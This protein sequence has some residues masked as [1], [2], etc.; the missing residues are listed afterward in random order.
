MKLVKYIFALAAAAAVQGA[1][2]QYYS[3]G[4]DPSSLRWRTIRTPEVRVVYPDTV[5]NIARRTL[6]Y[7]ERLQPFES[8]GF[9]RPPLRLS[10]VMHPENMLSNG[11]T[12]W[13]PKRID[14][15]TSPAVAGYSMPWLKQLAAHEYRHAV[16]YNNLNRGVIRVL[17]W[18]LGQQGSV[19]GLLFMPLWAIEGDAVTFETQVSTFGRGLQPSFSIHYRAA[20]RELLERRNPDKWFCG[21]YRDYIPDHYHIG[22]QLVSYSYDRYGERLWNDVTRFGVRNPYCFFTVRTGLKKYASTTV[23]QLFR[24][25]FTRLNDFWEAHPAPDD[26]SCALS[27][28]QGIYTVY[29][30]PQYAGGGILSLKSDL[31]HA[32]RFVTT[33]S[34]GT[35]RPLA[36]TGLLSSRPATDGQRVWWTEYRNSTLFA[37]R[38][39]SRLCFMDLGDGRTHTVRGIRDALYPTPARDRLARIAYRPDGRYSLVISPADAPQK[40]SSTLLLPEGIEIHGLAWD[41]L[42]DTFSVIVTDDQG[43]H[44]A[45][46][47]TAAGRLVPL[48]RSAYITLSDLRAAGGRLYFGSTASGRDEAHMIDLADTLQRRITD[49]RYGAF[50]PSPSPDGRHAAVTQFGRNGY[51]LAVQSLDTAPMHPVPWTETP[52]E[53]LNPPHR[54]IAHI[55]LD[56][57]RYTPAD[58]EES[59]RQHPS[60]RR[61][62]VGG[63][64]NI[65]SWM[66]LSLDIFSAVDEHKADMAFGATILSQNLQSS[67][68][69]YASYGWSRDEGSR[70]MGAIR[71]SGF[72]PQLSFEGRYGGNQIIYSM[73]VRDNEGQTQEQPV[74]QPERY[75]SL[76]AGISL[77]L[78][79]DAGYRS[80][81]LSLS[82][83]WNYSNGL[84][85]RI[86]RL[87]RDPETGGA[88]NLDRIGY[89]RGLHKLS[90]GLSFSE[91]VRTAYRDFLP[92]FGYVA[93]VNYSADPSNRLFSDMVSLYG[94]L[95]LPGV[96]AHHSLSL[97]AEYRTSVGGWRDASGRPALTFRSSRLLPT[98]FRSA[99]VQSDNCISASAAYRL[100]LCYP[101]GGIPGVLYFRRIRLGAEFDFARFGSAAGRRSIYSYG[102]E[103]VFDINLLR[104]PAAGG[105]AFTVRVFRT[106]DGRTVAESGIGLPF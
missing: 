72:G 31:A 2:A 40:P 95:Y 33:G 17:S 15:L 35:E 88:A 83:D 9:D 71:Y 82:A 65:H 24:D 52:R 53:I 100:P 51:R 66:P 56:T 19:I 67:A 99:D 92:R 91:Q 62:R 90:F 75:Y 12:M 30:W 103:A 26:S 3:W 8:E 73:T 79:L 44:I 18:P 96:A 106:S 78:R 86:D 38:V 34:D 37:E 5:E 22:Y 42:T 32:A 45:A 10:F 85:A 74:P 1:A 11:L 102:L 81:L 89:K 47:D 59:Q 16:Q 60:R 93:A 28:Q 94:R 97:A 57:V 39:N 25:T 98:G 43:M 6:Y 48:T 69:A 21:S 76:D 87:E 101:D 4:S 77:P 46:V 7:I 80:R 55:N 64:F 105:M 23:P 50:A 20:G 68:T 58:R 41:D 63:L 70:V 84:V 49:S 104:L 27:P 61:T 36:H 54:R 29:E 14:F 13:M